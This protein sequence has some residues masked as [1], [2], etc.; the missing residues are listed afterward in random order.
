[1][2]MT[3]IHNNTYIAIMA[4]ASSYMIISFLFYLQFSFVCSY[5]TSHQQ[6]D[7]RYYH[8]TVDMLFC[9]YGFFAAA[10][11]FFYFP[12]NAAPTLMWVMVIFVISGDVLAVI[13]D[14]YANVVAKSH[15]FRNPTN[16]FLMLKTL[17][18]EPQFMSLAQILKELWPY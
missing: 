8:I 9:L 11:F 16:I 13:L 10:F 14:L 4:M 2:A 15:S 18:V 6:H 12:H 3:C 17:G 7:Q 1:M 5:Y